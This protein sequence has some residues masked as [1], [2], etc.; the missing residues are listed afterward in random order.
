MR[1]IFLVLT[2]LSVCVLGFA[3]S[4]KITKDVYVFWPDQ[5]ETIEYNSYSV[6]IRVS[7][8]VDFNITGTLYC[9]GET[10]PIFIEAGKLEKRINLDNLDNGRR[11]GITVKLNEH[12]GFPKK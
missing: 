5:T 9:N 4:K 1:K 6:V 3:G 10:K 12:I 8:P 2:F 11:Y 7:N